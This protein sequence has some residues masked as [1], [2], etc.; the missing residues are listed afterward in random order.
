[1]ND[2]AHAKA[3]L[4]VDLGAESGRVFI[5]SCDAGVLSIREIH[6]FSNHPVVYG[7]TAHWDVPRLWAEIC[8]ALAS[9]DLEQIAS[10]GVDAWGVDYALIGESGELLQNPY[11][12]R[13]PRNVRA[14]EEVLKL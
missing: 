6:R 2:I 3:H 5:G 8:R 13:D 1:M 10:L 14:M 7:K 4:A 11:H 9:T 12:Y